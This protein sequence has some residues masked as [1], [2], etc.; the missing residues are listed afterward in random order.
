[1]V[2]ARL[3]RSVCLKI[4]LTDQLLLIHVM[5]NVKKKFE[6]EKKRQKSVIIQTD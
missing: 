4:S 2:V 1:V 6:E 3:V 5:K